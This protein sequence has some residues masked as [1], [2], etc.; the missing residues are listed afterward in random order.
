MINKL[1]QRLKNSRLFKDSFWA[2]LG[3]ALGKGLSLLGGI[4]VAQFLGKEIYGEYGMIKNTLMYIAIFSSFG[5]GYT[6]TKFI[7]ESKNRHIRKKV[8]THKIVT[9]ITLIASGLLALLLFAFAKP[10]AGWIDAPDLALSLRLSAIAIVF[11]AVNTTQTGELAGFNSY[12]TIAVNS[13]IA[14]VVTFIL[15]ICLTYFYGLNGAIVALILSLGCNCLLNRISIRRYISKE[16]LGK[17]SYNKKLFVQ[18]VKFSFP[19]ALQESLYSIVTW[20]SMLVLIKFSNYGE[21]G[22]LS[23]ATQWGA[24]LAFIPSSLRNVALSHLS[25]SNDAASENHTI[26][27]RLL[28]INFT[29]TIVPFV[30][31]FLLSGYISAWYGDSYTGLREVLNVCVFTTVINGLVNVY[32]QEL[33]AL[34]HN[35]FLFFTRLVRDSGVIISASLMIGSFQRVALGMAVIT[36]IFQTLY[37][38][39]VGIKYNHIYKGIRKLN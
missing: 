26:F 5:L 10:F 14:G 13:T 34:N 35:W 36:L 22:I 30:V 39:L 19:I 15:S 3:N 27:K 21:L 18:I 17:V 12:K 11:N 29:S 32:T 6:A 8:E 25:E 37:L 16:N 2:L 23:A 7:A 31:V 20:A 38:L 1:W 24:V 4:Y 9:L 33:I 28:A